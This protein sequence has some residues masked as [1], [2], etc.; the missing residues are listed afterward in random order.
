MRHRRFVIFLISSLSFVSAIADNSETSE[1]RSQA[2]NKLYYKNEVSLGY[3]GPAFIRYGNEAWFECGAA[4]S[5]IRY[6]RYLK[7]NVAVGGSVGF[8]WG[9][10]GL[11]SPEHQDN[12][13]Y[14]SF[15]LMGSAKWLYVNNDHFCMYMRGGLGVQRQR[16]WYDGQHNLGGAYNVSKIK[17]AI[18]L[19]PIAIEAGIKSVHAFLELGYGMEGIFNIGISYRFG[20]GN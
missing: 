8:A 14:N 17:G 9:S 7:R 19:T 15:Y 12:R 16:F 1:T 5:S 6:N 3:G 13:H 4:S 10:R 11:G 2:G 20:L 18:Q